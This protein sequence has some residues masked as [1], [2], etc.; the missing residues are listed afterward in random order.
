[1]GARGPAVAAGVDRSESQYKQNT[2]QTRMCPLLIIH[3]GLSVPSPQESYHNIS[4][5]LITR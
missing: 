5:T 2:D 3:V 4:Q 1:M